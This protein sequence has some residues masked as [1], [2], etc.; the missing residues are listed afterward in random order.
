M[1]KPAGVIALILGIAALIG[2]AVFMFVQTNKPADQGYTISP[3]E[4][5]AD[6]HDAKRANYL[7]R[8]GMAGSAPATGQDGSK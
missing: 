1:K 8:Q 4:S 2:L 6:G 3:P 7:K 5:D